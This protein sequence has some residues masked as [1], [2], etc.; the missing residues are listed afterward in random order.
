VTAVRVVP[1]PTGWR[2]HNPSLR[3]WGLA[4]PRLGQALPRRLEVRVSADA[5]AWH[6]VCDSGLPAAAAATGAWEARFPARAAKQVLVIGSGLPPLLNL[7]YCFSIGAVEVL[8][9]SGT[10]LA[11]VSRGAGVTVSSTNTGYGMDRW[12][13]EMLWPIQ[14]DVGFTWARVGYDFG[15]F[16][17]AS[18]ERQKGIL[19]VDP[20]ADE[21]ITEAVEHGVE[22]ILCLDKG[23]WLYAAEAK[24]PDPVRD[25]LD[26]YYDRP[27]EPT[28]SE[29]ATAGWLRYVRFMARHFRGRV[30]YFEVM[31]EWYDL[32]GTPAAYVEL[33]RRTAPVIRAECPDARIIMASASNP[34][35][36]DFI[37]P[38][39]DLGAGPLVDAVGW[40]G[41]G[42][43]EEVAAGD[44]SAA[45]D[46]A[47]AT[48]GAFRPH[49]DIGRDAIE[50]GVRSF[51]D[52][53]RDLR[54][55]C[56]E[57]GFRGE[58]IMTEFA[59]AASYPPIAGP[60]APSV[61][62]SELE[63]AIYAAQS[64]VASVGMDVTCLWNETFQ[65]QVNR[66][67]S[68]LRN[69]VAGDPLPP[70]QPEV[71]YYVVRTL[72]T[73][74]AGA[75]PAELAVVIEPPVPGVQRYGF[76]TAAGGRMVGLWMGRRTLAEP[77]PRASVD[78]VLPGSA[79][80]V[81]AL[82]VL[83][84]REREVSVTIDRDRTLVSG[85]VLD[86]LPVLLRW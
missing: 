39:L 29:E 85:L 17:W 42:T 34:N 70:V 20:R 24:R 31:N 36:G 2:V 72:C 81:V 41:L 79:A 73:A 78:L 5:R 57:R 33:L 54:R 28:E 3:G 45:R 16:T 35:W 55:R 19:A 14:Y 50:E 59:F 66:Q 69:T 22:I 51:G 13:Q 30:R 12:T 10:N 82:D 49:S 47:D 9:E 40:H 1:H 68:L 4:E 27:P 84:G 74:L 71:I 65:T 44:F 61:P 86:D 63:K 37:L 56:A 11:L 26:T 62:L 7:G 18:V 21:A 83:N 15:A 23:N 53:V 67:I 58:L 52:K 6:T 76:R 48:A 38:C 8:D 60:Q 64:V 25:V 77:R 80:T 43:V 75:D 32:V 46:G